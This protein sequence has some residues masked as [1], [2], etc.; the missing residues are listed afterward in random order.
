MWHELGELWFLCRVLG[1][2]DS[3]AW[4]ML[5]PITALGVYGALSPDRARG[6]MDLCDESSFLKGTPMGKVMAYLELI[7]RKLRHVNKRLALL[8]ASRG[9]TSGNGLCDGRR[10]DA[11]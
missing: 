9:C 3:L 10:P 11:R 1:W 2:Y 4:V 7:F 6:L 5:S 8:E